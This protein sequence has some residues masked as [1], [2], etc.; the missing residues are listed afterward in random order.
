VTAT[1]TVPPTSEPTIT[2]SPSPLPTPIS[3]EVAPSAWLT[4]ELDDAGLGRWFTDDGS[5]EPWGLLSVRPSE[6]GPDIARYA[7]ILLG[8]GENDSGPVL[9]VGMEDRMGERFVV[10]VQ[11]GS[12]QRPSFAIRETEETLTSSTSQGGRSYRRS[13]LYLRSAATAMLYLSRPVIFETYLST[14]FRSG[15]GSLHEAMIDQRLAQQRSLLR[16][17]QAVAEQDYGSSDSPAF[18][19]D[20]AAAADTPLADSLIVQLAPGSIP[21]RDPAADAAFALRMHERVE[22]W[23][24]G[25]LA[26]SDRERWSWR[27]GYMNF[28]LETGDIVN[29]GEYGR[30]MV[31]GYLLGAIRT[32]QNEV[33]L[34]VGFEDADRHR[35]MVPFRAGWASHPRISL[36]H[37]NSA[38]PSD[39]DRHP[40][41]CLLVD[42]SWHCFGSSYAP[43]ELYDELAR[44]DFVPVAIKFDLYMLRC[45]QEDRRFMTNA[46][47]AE[48]AS[49]ARVAEN[50][51]PLLRKA[52]K[53]S[54]AG[55]D[56][57]AYVD[58][59]PETLEGLPM[60]N[61]LTTRFC[62]PTTPFCEG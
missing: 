1:A 34:L 40:D 17:L 15:W 54:I 57:P 60:I 5:A 39:L 49:Y 13:L 11:F 30:Y 26:L 25:T 4:G 44:D 37:L 51:A 19:N 12:F 7:G 50:L 48:L 32:G 46:E 23:L 20:L 10:P 22:E 3:P 35:Y 24:A 61:D 36:D 47:C 31:V 14:D 18:V 45:N 9:F 8:I 43:D 6:G 16:F 33:A 41:S 56:R 28:G 29:K 27:L 42:F 38:Q 2:P 21:V 53:G 55:A 52:L 58:I 62:A 59:V